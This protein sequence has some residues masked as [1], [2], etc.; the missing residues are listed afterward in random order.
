[1]RRYYEVGGHVHRFLERKYS[2]VGS[3]KMFLEVCMWET[4]Y[5]G[6][7]SKR[8]PWWKQGSTPRVLIIT[9]KE[10]SMEGRK[11][12]WDWVGEAGGQE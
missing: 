2:T 9:L 4:V 10:A 6:R 7:C 3:P 12:Y 8:R 11:M 1:M 5:E